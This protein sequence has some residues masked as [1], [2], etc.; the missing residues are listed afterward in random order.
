MTWTIDADLRLSS[1]RREH[2]EASASQLA[3]LLY[4]QGIDKSKDAVQK[5]LRR[6]AASTPPRKE[7]GLSVPDAGKDFVGIRSTPRPTCW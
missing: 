7:A 5:R 3:D 4:E 2:P 6:I 1:L